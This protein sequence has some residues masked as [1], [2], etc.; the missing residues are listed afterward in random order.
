MLRGKAEYLPVFL[1][2]GYPT[3]IHSSFYNRKDETS[4]FQAFFNSIGRNSLGS[5][6][7]FS[8]FKI[9]VSV[10]KYSRSF[11]TANLNARKWW[12]ILL[13]PQGKK[14]CTPWYLFPK[15]TISMYPSWKKV[16][17]NIISQYHGLHILLGG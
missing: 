1:L 8:V 3:T 13:I 12:P 15:N 17:E 2:L 14:M 11:S 6:L 16:L 7:K 4:L 9:S 10:I 5:H